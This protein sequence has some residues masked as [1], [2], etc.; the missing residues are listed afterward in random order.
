MARYSV[1]GSDPYKGPTERSGLD[2]KIRSLQVLTARL[3]VLVAQTRRV[4]DDSQE[5]LA[6]RR[7]VS[8]N[9]PTCVTATALPLAPLATYRIEVEQLAC[10]HHIASDAL[11]ASRAVIPAGTYQFGIGVGDRMTAIAVDVETTDSDRDVLDTVGA[12]IQAAGVGVLA[13]VESGLGEHGESMRLHLISRATGKRA[14]LVTADLSRNLM[15][16]IGLAASGFAG[17]RNG[18]TVALARDAEFRIDGVLHTAPANRVYFEHDR[19]FLALHSAG[20]ATLTILP[21]RAAIAALL[22][23]WAQALG[24]VMALAVQPSVRAL[25]DPPADLVGTVWSLRSAFTAC[26]VRIR[27][28][29]GPEEI[30]E[31]IGQAIAKEPEEFFA[32]LSTPDAG[33]AGVVLD[34]AS[35]EIADCGRAIAAL[36]RQADWYRNVPSAKAARRLVSLAVAAYSP[37]TLRVAPGD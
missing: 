22:S 2:G 31:A 21:D 15:V 23:D 8:S 32:R 17:E 20:T 28:D 10:A 5:G 24:D 14:A 11:Q 33:L 16:L 1:L 12:A 34:A 26:G 36:G 25:L 19:L 35:K 3:D 29:A 37:S 9:G 18:G 30:P 7:T 27:E 4:S 6:S 13:R